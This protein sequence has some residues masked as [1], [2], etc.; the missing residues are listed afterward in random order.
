MKL[1]EF[2][3][4]GSLKQKNFLFRKGFSCDV[5]DSSAEIIKTKKLPD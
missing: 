2:I 1:N 4:S 3:F 5:L